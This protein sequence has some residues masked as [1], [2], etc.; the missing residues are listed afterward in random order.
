MIKN[1]EILAIIARKKNEV[2]C[3]NCVHC[4]VGALHSGKWYC[5]NRSVFDRIIDLSECF[6]RKEEVK[7]WKD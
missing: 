7:K 3:H 4:D 2:S 5:T 6:E 1:K